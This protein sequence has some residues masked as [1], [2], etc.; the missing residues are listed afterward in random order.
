[1]ARRRVSY[2]RR[3]RRGE[4]RQIETLTFGLIIVLFVL[5]FMFENLRSNP[6][7][8]TVI[9]GAILVGSA[10]YQWQRRFR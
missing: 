7:M 4:E 6:T 9:A 10:I 8:V 2:R 5:T 3:E 1:M